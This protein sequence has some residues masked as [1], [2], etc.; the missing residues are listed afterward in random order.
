MTSAKIGE[1]ELQLKANIDEVIAI[2][3]VKH[4]FVASSPESQ[5][6][7][8]TKP[9]AATNEDPSMQPVTLNG[10]DIDL[11]KVR[12]HLWKDISLATSYH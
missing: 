8:L 6:K 1:K 10:W 3:D 9:L 7:K 12:L 11:E 5:L 4:V 2:N